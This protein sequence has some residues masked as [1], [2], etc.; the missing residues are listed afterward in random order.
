MALAILLVVDRQQTF[1]SDVNIVEVYATAID[2]DGRLV[3]DLSKEDFE[4]RDNG[5]VQR[6]E[7]FSQGTQPITMSLMAD[8]SPSVLPI[9]G[10]IESAVTEFAKHFLPGDRATIG[11]FSHLIRLEPELSATPAALVER[12]LHDRPR[13]PSGTALWDALDAARDVLKRESGRRVVLVLTDADDNCSL[14]AP[15]DV[16]ARIE[17]EGTMVYAI[18]VKGNSGLPSGDLRSL[19]QDSGGYYFELRRDDDLPKTLARVAD[20][21][22]RQYVIGFSPA[23][24]DGKAHRLTV[25]AKRSGVTVRAR[26]TY[27]AAR[28]GE[29]TRDPSE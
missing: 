23:L 2:R 6:I 14:V 21:L 20:E 24:L 8:E 28:P 27:I 7:V 15:Q 19:T 22:H 11:A 4:I 12:V 26:R 3:A 17:R 10:R 16:I 25:T 9:A 29:G 18:G 1:R 13:F 5:Q